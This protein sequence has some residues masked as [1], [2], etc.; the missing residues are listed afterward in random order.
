MSEQYPHLVFHNFSS[1][2][3]ERIM[4]VLK[5]LFPVPNDDSKRV[6]TL[7]NDK[8]YISFRHHTYTKNAENAGKSDGGAGKK[9]EDVTLI[10]VGPRFEM[11]PYEIKLGTVDRP[12][13]ETEWVLKSYTNTAKKKRLL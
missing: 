2:L 11:Q 3:G 8:D 6:M 5:Y 9:G 10:E 1:S 7:Y 13:V 12:E 4:N